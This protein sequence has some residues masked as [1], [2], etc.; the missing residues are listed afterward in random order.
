MSGPALAEA[1]V[2]TA[3]PRAT[4]RRRGGLIAVIAVLVL[5]AIAIVV[6]RATATSST[7]PLAST[8]PGPEGS[9]AVV[10]V[11]QQ[12]GVRVV[13]T[14]S[15]RA[16]LAAISDPSDTTVMLYDPNS[17][18]S[19]AQRQR[20]LERRT[21]VVAVEPD[22]L[23]VG[24]I[25]PSASLAGS[26]SGTFSADCSVTAVKKAGTVTAAGSGYRIDSGSSAE[27]CLTK[28]GTSGL[29]Q[30][31]FEGRTVTVLGLGTALQNGTIATRG[32]AALALNL[33]GVH[34]TLIWYIS[35]PA[36][37]QGGTTATLAELTP[38]WVTPMLTL[39]VIAGAAALLWRGRRFGALVIENLPV[40]VRASETMEGRARLYAR[41]R[42]RLRALD[43]LRIGTIDR[44]SHRIGL[45]RAATVDEVIDAV[46][47]LLARDR[48]AIARLLLDDVP[49]TDSQ[50]VALSDQLL[51]LEADVAASATLPSTTHPP[52][53]NG[54]HG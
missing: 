49:G 11:L 44:L 40:V 30:E 32:D 19:T 34:H 54:Q 24:D 37:L 53:Q 17:Y 7:D 28:K 48:G 50:L 27:L 35:G 21:D 43:A 9:R 46:A 1:D 20:L 12:Q 8:N 38:A 13:T 51:T 41:S 36:D 2:L 16:T 4:L 22:L 14:D 18:L 39:L 10:Q 15:L 26:L 52:A 47:A 23:A 5:A 29:V 25:L 42:A 31:S 6:I 45:P 3:S 33:L